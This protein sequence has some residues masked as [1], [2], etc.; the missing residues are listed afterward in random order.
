MTKRDSWGNDTDAWE[1]W[2]N[3][4]SSS[5]QSSPSTATK[6]SPRAGKKGE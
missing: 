4:D 3:D 5:Y 6:R 2:L 1:N